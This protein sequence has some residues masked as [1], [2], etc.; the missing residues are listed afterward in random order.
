VYYLETADSVA[1]PFLHGAN[2]PQYLRILFLLNLTLAKRQFLC[3]SVGYVTTFSASG[4]NG[5]DDSMN[6]NDYEAFDGIKIS[7]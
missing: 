3:F 5:V 1:Q 4:L 7:R 2:T 6:M